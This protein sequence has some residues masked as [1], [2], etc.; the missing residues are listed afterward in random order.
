MAGQTRPL[1][2]KRGGPAPRPW[3]GEAPLATGA[4]GTAGAT[5]FD[6]PIKESVCVRAPLPACFDYLRGAKCVRPHARPRRPTA[7]QVQWF[8]KSGRHAATVAL[9]LFPPAGTNMCIMSAALQTTV[10]PSPA[11]L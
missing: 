2:R 3:Q 10:A 6:R 7:A 5:F 11:I 1:A 8:T 4:T 9:V